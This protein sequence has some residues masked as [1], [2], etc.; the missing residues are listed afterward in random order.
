M[1]SLWN[2]FGILVAGSRGSEERLPVALDHLSS[3]YDRSYPDW[4]GHHSHPD[5]VLRLLHR[6]EGPEAG[7]PG[8]IDTT[9]PGALGD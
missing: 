7:G 1:R 2:W 6:D 9:S 3:N 5:D 4:P 8:P